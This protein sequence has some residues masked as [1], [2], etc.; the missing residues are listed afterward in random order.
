MQVK[1]ATFD[2]VKEAQLQLIFDILQEL[3]E[4]KETVAPKSRRDYFNLL[5]ISTLGEMKD[6]SYILKIN[7]DVYDLGKLSIFS[8]KLAY[9]EDTNDKKQELQLKGQKIRVPVEELWKNLQENLYIPF[10]KALLVA[11]HSSAE[12]LKHS[13]EGL[14]Y[15]PTEEE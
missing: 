12:I 10:D 1:R 7:G 11:H 4:K 14:E 6:E 5:A 8:R 3:I 15:N 9:F 2:L 13:R